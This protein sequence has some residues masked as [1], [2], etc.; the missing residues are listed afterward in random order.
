MIRLSRMT[1][2]GVVVM[3]QMSQQPDMTTAPELAQATGLPIP[4]VSKLLKQL[5]KSGLVASH[6]GV[7]GGYSIARK[8]EDIN[9]MEIIEALDGPVAL[10]DCV[11]GAEDMCNVQSLC[12]LRGG[13]DKVNAAV[14]D[15]LTEVTLAELCPPQNFIDPVGAPLDRPKKRTAVR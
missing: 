5:T 14:R 2:Y 7:N 3:S 13:W 8:L 12:P 6:R 11:D 1:D 15:A 4:T 10:T 9:A